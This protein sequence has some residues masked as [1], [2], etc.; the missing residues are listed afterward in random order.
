[1]SSLEMERRPQDRRESSF[2]GT[3]FPYIFYSCATRTS[4]RENTFGA[5]REKEIG[6]EPAGGWLMHDRYLDLHLNSQCLDGRLG[7]EGLRLMHLVPAPAVRLSCKDECYPDQALTV[8]WLK[9]NMRLV[10][11]SSLWV[12]NR[13][14]VLGRQEVDRRS[15]TCWSAMAGTKGSGP[16]IARPHVPLVSQD[17]KSSSAVTTAGGRDFFGRQ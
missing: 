9:D 1:M 7:D 12:F 5:G 16:L 3:Q 14:Q 8:Y 11:H 10:C 17:R 13:W 15:R 6:W 2:P 4:K